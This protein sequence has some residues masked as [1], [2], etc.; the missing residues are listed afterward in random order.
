VVKYLGRLKVP[1]TTENPPDGRTCAKAVK[2]LTTAVTRRSKYRGPIP[3][4][5]AIQV[6]C[7]LGLVSC[8]PAEDREL[9]ADED[10][11]VIKHSLLRVSCVADNGQ[12]LCYVMARYD[13]SVQE[14]PPP[15]ICYAYTYEVRDHAHLI[16]HTW[17]S[18]CSFVSTLIS[19]V[20]LVV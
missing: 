2:H 12:Y 17:C 10:P 20:P 15:L 14:D 18:A 13:R 7:R 5:L 16:K 8:I 4:W 19:L 6:S 3:K 1:G 11:R 9:G